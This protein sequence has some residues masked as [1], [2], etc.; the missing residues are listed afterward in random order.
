[1]K[2]KINSLKAALPAFT[3]VLTLMGGIISP[4]TSSDYAELLPQQPPAEIEQSKLDTEECPQPLSDMD[5]S[6]TQTYA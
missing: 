6:R 2:H 3:L 1:M 4:R 5:S